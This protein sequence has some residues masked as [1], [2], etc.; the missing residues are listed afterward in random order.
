MRVIFRFCV[1]FGVFA[2]IASP[3]VYAAPIQGGLDQAAIHSLYTEGEFEKAEANLLAFQKNH[4]AYS[5]S[6]SLF[7]AK[8]LSVIYSANPDT[9]EKGKYHM[10]QLLTLDPKAKLVDMIISDEIDRI[11]TK[12]KEEF[13]TRLP[14]STP[15]QAMSTDASAN[16]SVLPAR[17][18]AEKD[19]VKVSTSKSASNANRPLPQ[20][21]SKKSGNGWWLWPLAGAGLIAVGTT[22]YLVLAEPAEKTGADVVYT[23]DSKAKAP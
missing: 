21:A 13:E 18:L 20:I 11:F 7:I 19:S 9:R 17:R 15:S 5:R 16:E 22:A 1:L 23:V 4:R 3:A 2:W 8:H 14:V 6:D 10:Y 12:V